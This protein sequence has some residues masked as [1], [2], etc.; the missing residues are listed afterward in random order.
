M[1][2]FTIINNKKEIVS[3]EHKHKSI[4]ILYVF[5]GVQHITVSDNLY[6]INEGEAAVIFPDISHSYFTDSKKSASSLMIDFDPSYVSTFYPAI[7]YV[8]PQN[9]IISS[10]KINGETL[11]ALEHISKNPPI[12]KKLAYL[13]ILFSNLYNDLS[14]FSNDT[15]YAKKIT[16]LLTDYI[17]FNYSKPI[18]RETLAKEFNVSKSLISR[19]F[20]EKFNMNIKTYLGKVRTEKAALYLK[21]GDMSISSICKLSGFESIRT[22]NRVFLKNMGMSPTEYRNKFTT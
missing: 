3:K 6:A 15:V 9:P 22:F 5:F 8:I 4:E 14:V 19:I 20:S 18:S 17:E 12:E 7:D 21:S 10:D 1:K 16:P 13:Y 2:E 11:F